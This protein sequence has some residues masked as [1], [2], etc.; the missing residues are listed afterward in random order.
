MM[1]KAKRSG[2]RPKGV[3]VKE[4]GQKDKIQAKEIE[5]KVRMVQGWYEMMR[6]QSGSGKQGQV[7]KF[8]RG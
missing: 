3:G 8:R 5:G 4:V 6:G 2:N 7:E 1:T